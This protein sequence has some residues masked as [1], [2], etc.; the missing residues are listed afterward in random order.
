MLSASGMTLEEALKLEEEEAAEEEKT[1]KREKQ[2]NV[3]EAIDTLMSEVKLSN[4]H[5][6]L[7][8]VG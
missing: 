4:M 1:N 3:M 5:V 8:D 7:H 6:R 2:D